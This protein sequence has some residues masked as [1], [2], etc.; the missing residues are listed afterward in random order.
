MD[1][2]D[3]GRVEAI[4]IWRASA[5]CSVMGEEREAIGKEEMTK[6]KRRRACRVRNRS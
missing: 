1:G 4:G 6:S 3:I 2:H 5:R